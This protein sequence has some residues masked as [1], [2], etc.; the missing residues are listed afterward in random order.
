MK[1]CTK[2]KAE[3]PVDR[4]LKVSR[5]RDGLSAQCGDCIRRY[6]KFR[7]HS[8]CE[9]EKRAAY[10]AQYRITHKDQT[11]TY[12]DNYNVASPRRS[13]GSALRRALK[14]KMTANH[15]TIDDLMRMFEANGGRCMLSGV[16]MTWGAREKARKPSLHSISLDR[17]D[18]TKGYE[19]GNV[20]IICHGLNAL[21]G[22]WS[23]KEMMALAVALVEFQ[24][25]EQRHAA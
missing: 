10:A 2:C 11:K 13:L 17:I 7:Y 5:N 25:T 20:R 3:K 21:R 23:D 19:R 6:R 12:Q 4:F 8:G 24:K 15:V 9:H 18:N 22:G 1:K 16:K 14:R